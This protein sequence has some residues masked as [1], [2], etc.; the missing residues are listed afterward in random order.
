MTIQYRG[1]YTEPIV[2]AGIPTAFGDEGAIV[3]ILSTAQGSFDAYIDVPNHAGIGSVCGTSYREPEMFSWLV[4]ESSVSL[5]DIQAGTVA[6]S[7]DAQ[8]AFDWVSVVLDPPIVAAPT[9]CA[10]DADCAA[11]FHCDASTPGTCS[12]SW[13]VPL[14]F[15]VYSVASVS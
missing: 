15:H 1:D 14:S 5:G 2:V 9:P 7:A 10:T 3:R 12:G 11:D 4:V 8:H 13:C 6:S